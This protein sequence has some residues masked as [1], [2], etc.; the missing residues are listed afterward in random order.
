MSGLDRSV[1][2]HAAPRGP[3]RAGA[4]RSPRVRALLSIGL[5]LGFGAISTMA[6][7]SDT[8]TATGATFTSGVLD[9]KLNGQ[10]SVDLS[11]TFTLATMVPG[12]SVAAHVAVQNIAPSN[13]AFTYT[14]TGLA[15]GALA[16]YLSFQVFLGGTSSNGTAG[17]LRTGSCTGT[18]TGAAQTMTTTMTV[19]GTPQ[20]L[21]VGSSQNVCVVATLGASTPS[22]MQG[23][24]GSASFTFTAAQLGAP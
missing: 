18:S 21:T 20:Q 4:R 17:G 7:W 23:T 10:N 2:R 5:I 19:I 1:P 8:E 13:V 22:N 24:T 11:S 12:E 15:S 9:M 16:P 14:A 3:A 6:Y